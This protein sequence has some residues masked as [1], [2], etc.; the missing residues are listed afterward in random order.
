MCTL[1]V[2]KVFKACLWSQVLTGLKMCHFMN[3]RP[4][5]G[6][7]LAETMEKVYI[8]GPF[9]KPGQGFCFGSLLF[10]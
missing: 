2:S 8:Y 6:K 7:V 9:C 5:V 3:V 10:H 1:Y 4:D